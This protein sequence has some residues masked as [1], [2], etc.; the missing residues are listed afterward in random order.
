MLD[1][2]L[3]YITVDNA[4]HG[5]LALFVLLLLRLLFKSVTGANGRGGFDQIGRF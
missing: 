1:L 3:P 2:L 4:L 5:T